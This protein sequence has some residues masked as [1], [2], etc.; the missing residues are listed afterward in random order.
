AL[1]ARGRDGEARAAMEAARDAIY[2]LLIAHSPRCPSPVQAALRSR[3]T[4]LGFAVVDLPTTFAARGVVPDRRFFLD[5]CHLTID[6]MR[7]ALAATAQA[8]AGLMAVTTPP[9]S[10]LEQVEISIAPREEALAHLLAAIHNAHWG[11]NADVI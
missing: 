4:E 3:A 6:G 10:E 9:A 8:V 2:G 7:V 11:Q 1:L 5:Y